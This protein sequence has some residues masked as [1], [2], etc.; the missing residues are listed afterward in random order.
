MEPRLSQP[1]DNAPLWSLVVRLNT[2]LRQ[3]A[4]ADGLMKKL[5]W[6]HSCKKSW[7]RSRGSVSSNADV[8]HE[9]DGTSITWFCRTFGRFSVGCERLGVKWKYSTLRVVRAERSARNRVREER[10][11]KCTTIRRWGQSDY[12]FSTERFDAE[13][14]K[15]RGNDQA[16]ITGRIGVQCG[17]AGWLHDDQASITGRHNGT[18]EPDAEREW[19]DRLSVEC[20]TVTHLMRND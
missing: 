17:T 8:V 3:K 10:S 2:D 11:E 19:A 13:G 14:G 6:P 12:T 18:K 7:D 16:S 4:D 1:Q 5:C 9:R 20:W 15:I